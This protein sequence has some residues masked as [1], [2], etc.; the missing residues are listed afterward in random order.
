VIVPGPGSA[1]RRT[2][3]LLVAT[4]P[5]L[6]SWAPL[7]VAAVAS[8]LLVAWRWSS[9]TSQGSGLL[10]MRSVVLL[11]V[12]GG[13]FLLDDPSWSSTESMPLPQRWRVGLRLA[14]LALTTGVLAGS[15]WLLVASRSLIGSAAGGVLLEGSA[16]LLVAAAI[17]LALRRG[18]GLDEPAQAAGVGVLLLVL[19]VPVVEP[20]WPMLVAPGPDWGD[21]HR[22]WAGLAVA[23]ASVLV[24]SLRD[25]ASRWR[26]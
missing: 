11:L 21:A 22:R 23:A 26:P 4:F 15:L 25:P 16:V 9:L 24:A 19:V 3:G 8:G 2:A 20:R 1:R 10:V 5:R 6:L 14:V 17:A 18:W 7:A 12:L 13:V